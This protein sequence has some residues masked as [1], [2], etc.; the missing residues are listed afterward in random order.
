[1]NYFQATDFCGTPRRPRLSLAGLPQH[2]IV[3]GNIRSEIF[4]AD[5]YVLMTVLFATL[6]DCCVSGAARGHGLL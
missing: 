6:T 5:T 1:V 2:V 3:R 4:C